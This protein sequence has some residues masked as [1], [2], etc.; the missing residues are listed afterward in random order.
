MNSSPHKFY[1]SQCRDYLTG[2]TI[3]FLVIRVNRHMESCHPADFCN[4]TDK[5]IVLSAHYLGPIGLLAPAANAEKNDWGG[6]EPPNI[7]QEDRELL[8]KGRVIWD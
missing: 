4:W 6:A 3:P 2:I 8:A 7:T 1:C 5:N